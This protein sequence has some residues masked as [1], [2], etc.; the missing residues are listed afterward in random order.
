LGSDSPQLCSPARRNFVGAARDVVKLC[1]G[2]RVLPTS[3]LALQGCLLWAQNPFPLGPVRAG[4]DV[5]G[6]GGR[7]TVGCE[8]QRVTSFELR[9]NREPPSQPD[10]SEVG[11]G[12]EEGEGGESHGGSRAPLGPVRAGD[13]VKGSGGR[14][15]VGCER[16]R[17]TS[18]EQKRPHAMSSSFA[19]GC[20]SFLHPSLPCKDAFY[21]LKS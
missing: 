5:K 4:D 10:R 15:T 18:F 7:H 3:F 2:V 21:G 16:Q 6:S 20:A 12:E 11:R 17:V 8:R 14:H 19:A 9:L 13:D 1:S